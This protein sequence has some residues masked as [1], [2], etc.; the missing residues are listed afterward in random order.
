MLGVKLLVMLIDLL[1]D[2]KFVIA[3]SLSIPRNRAE[4]L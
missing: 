2:F 3:H 4:R 1:L